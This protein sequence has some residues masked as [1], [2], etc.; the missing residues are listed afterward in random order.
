MRA[1]PSAA[2]GASHRARAPCGSCSTAPT[3]FAFLL[4]PLGGRDQVQ[5]FIERAGA[6]Q[7]ARGDLVAGSIFTASSNA[8]FA[9]AER[10]SC[11]AARRPSAAAASTSPARFSSVVSSG[12]IAVKCFERRDVFARCVILVA[13]RELVVRALEFFAA[14]L[15]HGARAQLLQPLVDR[16]RADRP[17]PAWRARARRNRLPSSR[18][19]A[20]ARLCG[21]DDAAGL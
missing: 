2:R 10:P 14:P 15:L 4:Q 21:A 17:P 1:R 18:L 7:S 19:P 11:S 16:P 20:L 5:H 9:S 6:L 3:A 12:S 8:A 13:G